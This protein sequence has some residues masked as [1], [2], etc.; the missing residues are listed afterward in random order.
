MSLLCALIGERFRYLDQSPYTIL[1]VTYLR[2]DSQRSTGISNIC[3]VSNNPHQKDGV[4]PRLADGL[5]Q[6]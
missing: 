5:H 3:Q 2:R 1:D 4:L 6:L